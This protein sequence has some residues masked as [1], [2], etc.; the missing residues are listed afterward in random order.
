MDKEFVT[1]P[2]FHYV[3]TLQSLSHPA[4][5]YTGQTSDIRK[6]LREHNSGKVPHTLKSPTLGDNG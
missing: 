6:R 5:I 1:V 3:Y 4:Q 2:T